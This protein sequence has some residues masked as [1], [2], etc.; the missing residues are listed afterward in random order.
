MRQALFTFLTTFVDIDVLLQR[1]THA[2][3]PTLDDKSSL[4][5]SALIDRGRSLFQKA[6]VHAR[7]MVHD[8]GTLPSIDAFKID[9]DNNVIDTFS[10]PLLPI[11]PDED[12]EHF[13]ALMGQ[14]TAWRQEL[15][16]FWSEQG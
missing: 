11:V 7:K 10:M 5:L 3:S 13:F 2:L 12:S 16:A 9:A 15:E 6:T 4:A 1:Y 8:Q 14:L